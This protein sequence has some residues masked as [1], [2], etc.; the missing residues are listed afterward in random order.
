M[1]K[2]KVTKNR[3]ASLLAV[4]GL[5]VVGG[6]GIGVAQ[7]DPAAPIVSANTQARVTAIG[8][9]QAS[10]FGILRRDQRASDA[11]ATNA[12]GPFGAN[13]TLARRVTG[14]AGDV[15]VV[16][17]NDDYL[18]LRGEDS[19]GSVWTCTP[20]DVAEAGR[21]VLSLRTPGSS[22]VPVYGV[23][24]DGVKSVTL[25]D[26]TG[27]RALA[28]DNNVYTVVADSPTSVE[29]SDGSGTET[30]RVP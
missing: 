10:A 13:L 22:S 7:G 14:D 2:M 16:P 4:G 9:D 27:T 15:R 30:V 5:A 6:A 17:A 20:T 29:Y 8:A 26:A 3:L 1:S 24:P 11:I 21:L 19:V 18:C 23:V 28:V 25:T 12:K